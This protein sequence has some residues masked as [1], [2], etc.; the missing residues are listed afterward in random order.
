LIDLARKEP[1][2]ALAAFDRAVAALP[3][4]QTALTQSALLGS[5]GYAREG[6][7][8]LDAFLAGH[9][10]QPARFGFSAA[11]LHAWL[12]WH[13]GYWSDEFARVRALLA[14][15]AHA[16]DNAGVRTDNAILSHDG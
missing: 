13:Y 10:L 8:H 1:A 5:A 6:L 3:T 7:R 4:P 2:K 9:P 14:G 15:D 16:L 11:Q 12:L